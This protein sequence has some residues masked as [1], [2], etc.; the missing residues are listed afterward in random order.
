MN[1]IGKMEFLPLVKTVWDGTNQL[2]QSMSS[3]FR[4]SKKPKELKQP[5]HTVSEEK[6]GLLTK[7]LRKL[8]MIYVR[9]NEPRL[10]IQLI[11]AR[12]Q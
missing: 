1:A 9:N 3:M 2:C 8:I 7:K 10:L 5:I 12:V 4:L 6:L 11:Q